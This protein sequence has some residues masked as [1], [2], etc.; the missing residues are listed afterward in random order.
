M[1]LQM[2]GRVLLELKGREGAAA[3]VK[4]ALKKETDLKKR[5]GLTAAYEWIMKAPDRLQA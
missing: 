5:E 1:S 3:L 2:G 4:D